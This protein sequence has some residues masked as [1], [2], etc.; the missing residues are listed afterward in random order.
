MIYI[1]PPPPPKSKV[2]IVL[3]SAALV[4]LVIGIWLVIAN[5]HPKE[6][7]APAKTMQQLMDEVNSPD[8][9]VREAAIEE[10]ARKFPHETQP[11]ARP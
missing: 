6:A 5:V 3:L 8:P 11:G 7:P 1:P 4:L 10:M 2:K 9:R